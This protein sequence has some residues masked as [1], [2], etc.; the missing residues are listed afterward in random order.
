[1]KRTKGFQIDVV[2]R[3]KGAQQEIHRLPLSLALGWRVT[4]DVTST[5]QAVT[6]DLL[7]RDVPKHPQECLKQEARVRWPNLPERF[8]D[9]DVRDLQFLKDP[10]RFRL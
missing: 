4:C 5:K 6:A 7:I 3:F 2:V 9:D 1:M 8:L 10:F